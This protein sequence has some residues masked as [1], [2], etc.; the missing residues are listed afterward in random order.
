M[1]INHR[2]CKGFTLLE[3][4]IAVLILAIGLLGMAG[5]QVAGLRNNYSAYLR[6]Q[7]TQLA[8]DIA[9]RMR[10]NPAGVIGGSYNNQAA[11]NSA[12]SPDCVS[13]SCTSSQMASKD[14][15]DWTTTLAAQLPNGRGVVCIDSSPNDGTFASNACDGVG[16]VY[17]IKIWWNDEYDRGTGAVVVK[18]F[19][20][21][22]QP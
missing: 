19:A 17:A 11:P 21:S 15:F 14:L 5:L 7:S 1:S 22:F 16:N 12:P 4:L 18:Q 20:T 8:Y 3:V 2:F 10:A 13:N 9:D 6:S